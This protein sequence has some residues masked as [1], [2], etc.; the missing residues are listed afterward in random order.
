M[1]GVTKA[2]SMML[3]CG[4]LSGCAV[5]PNFSAPLAPAAAGYQVTPLNRQTS[6]P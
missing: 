5:G 6:A 3:A 4:L 2:I 1:L